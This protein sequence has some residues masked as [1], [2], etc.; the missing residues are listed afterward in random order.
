MHNRWT[1]LL[2][3]W[4][5]V[6]IGTLARP[7]AEPKIEVKVVTDRPQAMY[8]AGEEAPPRNYGLAEYPSFLYCVGVNTGLPGVPRAAGVFFWLLFLAEFGIVFGLA[9][10]LL[11]RAYEGQGRKAEARKVL[12]EAERL[13]R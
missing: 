2:A 3:T 5:V 7:Q 11:G 6:S 13:S 9:W 12:E 10:Q 8:H 1:Y 4:T